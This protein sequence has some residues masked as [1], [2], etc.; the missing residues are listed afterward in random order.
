MNEVLQPIHTQILRSSEWHSKGTKL[1]GSSTQCSYKRKPL[2]N[3][4]SFAEHPNPPTT[5]KAH[6]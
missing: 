1:Q 3:P 5:S 2:M 6:L 4:R